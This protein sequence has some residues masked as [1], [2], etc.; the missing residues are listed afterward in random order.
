LE[1]LPLLEAALALYAAHLQQTADPPSC[2]RD[3]D[4]AAAAEPPVLP[5]HGAASLPALVDAAE[6]GEP[7][8]L[9]LRDNDADAWHAAPLVGHV[10]A[11]DSDRCAL[12]AVADAQPALRFVLPPRCRFALS[13]AARLRGCAAQLRGGGG[14]FRLL[15]VDPPWECVSV[16]RSNAYAT[17]TCGQARALHCVPCGWETK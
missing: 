3:A 12:A 6:S 1:A 9:A 5:H 14:G 4:N 11:N 7:L 15:V 10:H 8:Q 13:S 2:M 16:Q 17:L